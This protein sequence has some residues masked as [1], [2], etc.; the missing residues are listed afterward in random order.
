[1]IDSGQGCSSAQQSNYVHIL[2]HCAVHC[3]IV[4]GMMN[5]GL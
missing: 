3:D 2:C 4:H 1:M 5:P